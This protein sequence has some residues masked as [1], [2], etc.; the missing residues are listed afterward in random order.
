MTMKNIIVIYLLTLTIGLGCFTQTK[1]QSQT[2]SFEDAAVELPSPQSVYL[3]PTSR[4]GERF[5]GNINFLHERY[6]NYGEKMINAFAERHYAPGGFLEDV[7]DRE[8]GGKWLDAAVRVGANTNDFSLLSKAEYF[9]ASLLKLQQPDGYLGIKLPTDR[10]LNLWEQHWDMWSQWYGMVGFLSYY[11]FRGGSE[12]LD[13]A[14][15][16]ADWVIKNFG[17]I[18]DENA[19]FLTV[20]DLDGGTNT[21]IIGQFI[22]LYR[23]TG[24]EALLEFVGQVIEYYAPIQRMISSG[25][26]ELTHPY[27]L[28][29]YLGGTIEYAQVTKNKD[30]LAWVEKIWDRMVKDHLY[31]TGSLG[32][33]EKLRPGEL[34]D[35]EDASFQETCATTEWMFFTQS[36][37]QVTGRAKY[38]EMLEKTIFNSLLAAQ[39]Q[40]GM[41]W[42]YFTPLRSHK[43][44]FHG[45]TNCC[46]WSGPRGIARIPQL[47]YTVS[48]NNVN[49]NFFETSSASLTT[50]AGE[51]KI[52]QGSKF[53]HTGESKIILE[54]AA[55]WSGKL[56]I[57]IPSWTNEFNVDV[58]G[59]HISSKPSTDGYHEIEL[60]GAGPHEIDLQ[61]DIPIVRLLFSESG[62][63]KKYLE[64][65]S[66]DNFIKYGSFKIF[67][68]TYLYR[69][70]P[71]VLSIDVRDQDQASLDW[72]LFQEDMEFKT[73]KPDNGRRRY[74]SKFLY[75]S[76]PDV[77]RSFMF[78]PYADAGNN[79]AKFKT[80]F[81]V[82]VRDE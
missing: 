28:C 72:I 26:P 22:R 10:E 53:P 17:P 70:G 54:A 63:L 58:K 29:A 51:V 74:E 71:E 27:M 64:E 9:A 13:A 4:L 57:R 12:Y 5:H 59:N 34:Q 46:Y 40:D 18:E 25:E 61:F 76:S 42:C 43:D 21:A 39:S 45:P 24:N 2:F 78:T 20:G 67:F 77:P 15:R 49:V 11:E 44:W 31:P 14:S 8:Y 37:Y 50:K 82:G 68:P 32:E 16:I 60:A 52:S 1:S 69:R 81:A 80:V 65:G 56:L 19:K 23:H 79:G 30:I 36:L 35:K 38:L 62:E 48:G 3:D 66:T 41:K 6:D 73:G 75:F 47:L 55:D 7:W 33:G